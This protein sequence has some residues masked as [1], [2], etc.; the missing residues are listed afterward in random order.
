V[1]KVASSKIAKSEK[2]WFDNQHVVITVAFDTFD[3]LAPKV[4]DLL[5]RVQ[6][7]MHSNVMSLRSINVMFT[8]IDF[9]I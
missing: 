8:M 4:V 9:A 7:V 5:L 2:A 1:L 6:R 3:C